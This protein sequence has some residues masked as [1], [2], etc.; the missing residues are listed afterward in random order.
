ML[1]SSGY[2][3]SN[4]P[5]LDQPGWIHRGD[6]WALIWNAREVATVRAQPGGGAVVWLDL[7]KMWETEE[8]RAPTP[9]VG[10]RYAERRAAARLYP[11]VPEAQAISDLGGDADLAPLPT[12]EGLPQGF[13]WIK[14]SIKAKD[15]TVIAY[16]DQWVVAI[17]QDNPRSPLQAILALHLDFP[18]G[19]RPMRTCSSLQQGKAGAEIWVARHH[20]SIIREIQQ[21][22][23]RAQ[24]PKLKI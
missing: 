17:H 21:A 18:Q 1:P 24:L 4:S 5:E 12:V 8:A 6:R 22:R 23:R 13:R 20:E 7:G 16:G 2:Q 15:R 3:G 14:P 19:R 9:E 11:G 10:R